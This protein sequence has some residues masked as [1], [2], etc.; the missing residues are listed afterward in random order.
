M[1]DG[2]K[3]TG[4][5]TTSN[6]EFFAISGLDIVTASSTLLS[7][8]RNADKCHYFH[9]RRAIIGHELLDMIKKLFFMAALLMPGLAYVGNLSVD[10][11]IQVVPSGTAPTSA[12]IAAVGQCAPVTA[13]LKKPR[14]TAVFSN[15]CKHAM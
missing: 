5:L 15:A 13:P 7:G 11:S 1:S 14:K 3:F 12:S 6:T 10:L 8:R 4:T 2:S 9:A